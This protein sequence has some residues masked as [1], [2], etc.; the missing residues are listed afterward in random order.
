[1]NSRRFGQRIGV[2]AGGAAIIT[3]IGLT[4]ACGGGGK[5]SPSSTTTTPHHHDDHLRSAGHAVA[6]REEHQ[7]HGWQPVHASGDGHARTEHPA[8]T[9][10]GYRWHQLDVRDRG[11]PDRD[12]R[13]FDPPR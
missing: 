13:G 9:A 11:R 4:A 5:E 3:M 12:A 10:L 8:G 1:M 6:H 2:F 7:P